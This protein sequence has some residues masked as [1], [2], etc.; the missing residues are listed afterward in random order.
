[1]RPSVILSHFEFVWITS[2]LRAVVPEP[3]RA[4]C[5]AVHLWD[6]ASHQRNAGLRPPRSPQASGPRRQGRQGFPQPL[7]TPVLWMRIQ[8]EGVKPMRIRIRI[9]ILVRLYSHKKL[10]FYMKNILE[11]GNR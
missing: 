5:A 8:I 10:A 9:R 6:Q 3:G 4:A 7:P 11:V 2:E 1:M